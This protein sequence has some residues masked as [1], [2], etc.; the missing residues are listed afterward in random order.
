MQC[1]A[2]SHINVDCRSPTE[3]R[4]K[5]KNNER[6][7][8]HQFLFPQALFVAVFGQA[9]QYQ[10]VANLHREPR[11]SFKYSQNTDT[12]L[13][14]RK[15]EKLLCFVVGLFV[16]KEIENEASNELLVVAMVVVLCKHFL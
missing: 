1:T 2:H 7:V 6:K 16:K 11:F 12:Q 10:D 9:V 3:N 15:Y 14:R 5:G 4:E 13:Y 8:F